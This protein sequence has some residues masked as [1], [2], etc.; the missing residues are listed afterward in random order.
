[1]YQAFKNFNRLANEGAKVIII[2]SLII[3]TI[4][5]FSQVVFRYVLKESLSWSEEL[6]RYFFIWLTFIGAS[7][8]A[9]EKSHIC[10]AEFIARIKQNKLRKMLMVFA[11]LLSISFLAILIRYGVP[12]AQRII[13]LKQVSPSMPFLY[14]GIVYI[15]IPI[16]SLLMLFNLL[17]IFI[18]TWFDR[19]GQKG[20][21][22]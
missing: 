21:E 20:G 6:A 7:V 18:E 15:A 8:A 13:K 4:L 11:N 3:M 10:V 17:E 2:F 16:G 9:R 14:V 19:E 22:H 1:M 12:I 5:V